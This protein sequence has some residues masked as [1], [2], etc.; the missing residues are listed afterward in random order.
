[1]NPHWPSRLLIRGD[2]RR[3]AVRKLVKPAKVQARLP[4]GPQLPP[5]SYQEVVDKASEPATL[6]RAMRVWYA[7]ARVEWNRIT[8]EDR[9][10]TPARFTWASAAGPLAQR[11]SGSSS[12]SGMWR[13]LARRAQDVARAI[14]RGSWPLEPLQMHT[15]EGHLVAAT[16]AADSLCNSHQKVAK[17]I[18]RAWA[19]SLHAAVSAFSAPWAQSL[20]H[21]ADIK[22]KVLEC[23]TQRLRSAE[24][25]ASIGAPSA[26]S[27]KAAPTKLAYRWVRGLV[28]WQHSPIGAADDNE[29]VPEVD[30]DGEADPTTVVSDRAQTPLPAP[31]ADQ[32]VVERQADDLAA[33]WKESQQLEQPLWPADEKMKEH[34][35]DTLLPWAIEAAAKSFPAGTDLGADNISPR[36]IC[37]LSPQAL[38]ALA[39]LF[40][41]FEACGCWAEVLNLVLIVLLPKPDG[42]F[43]P[44][45]LFPTIIRVWM[46][47]RVCVAKAWEVANA[48]P[49]LFGGPGMG[50]Q[51]ASWQAAFASEMAAI[52][53]LDHAQALLDLVKAFEMIPHHLVVQAALDRGYNLV[54]LRLSLAAYKL[55]RAVGID[56][57]FSRRICARRGITAGSGFATTELRLLLQ[58]VIERLQQ[59][60]TAACVGIKLYVDDLTLTVTG[61][62]QFVA[63]LLKAVVDFVID[64][65]EK[66]LLLDVSAKKSGIVAGRPRLARHIAGS[67]RSQK[68]RPMPHAKL[69]GTGAAGCRRRST[70]T[71]KVRQWAFTKTIGRYHSLRQSGVNVRQMVRAAGPP[72]MLYGVETIGLSDSSLQ[73]TRSRVA[74]A[75]APQAGGKNP[76]LTL[77][78]LDGAN[79]CLDPAFDV[80][81]S[82]IKHWALAWWEKWEEPQALEA[83]FQAAGLR[84]AS[85]AQTLW[86]RVTGPTTALL[87]SM[88]RL[89]WVF[90]SAR[91]TVDDRG[92]SWSFQEDSPAAIVRACRRSVRRWRIRRVMNAFPTLE[93]E[94]CDYPCS[95]VSKT[96]LVDF[97]ASVSSMLHGKASR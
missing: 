53:K 59:R 84:L 76:D 74:I 71:I 20:E 2:A 70:Y 47:A 35:L 55:G 19:N 5:P 33:I 40:R 60:W 39:I 64:I 89:G 12:L 30:E 18:V 95:D 24:W 92:Q 31:M 29:G 32:I 36:A 52:M 21:V 46:R 15:L 17:P 67:L 43:R 13:N 22:A 88:D 86:R 94:T 87:A 69:L 57:A 85:T 48:H 58:G 54:V 96:I 8:G 56:G 97:S 45:G 38:I 78:A 11:W 90:P 51:R 28:G 23:A 25:R 16:R 26:D 42:G 82:P 80:H 6:D 37:R 3:H 91:E 9:K 61:T 41:Q 79:G 73:V 10:F 14:E 72:A 7:T 62:P 34:Q 75:A 50:A 49:C 63:R 4:Q 83:A 66:E 1:M 77:L 27:P 65:L 68:A 44:I 93:P 81:V